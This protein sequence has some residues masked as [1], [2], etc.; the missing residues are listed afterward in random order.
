MKISKIKEKVFEMGV[1]SQQVRD[2]IG[3]LRFRSTWETAYDKYCCYSNLPIIK[4][5]NR[6]WEI[7]SIIDFVPPAPPTFIAPPATPSEPP[8]PVEDDNQY[9]QPRPIPTEDDLKLPLDNI[10]GR[11]LPTEHLL[12][13]FN[14]V[15]T[16]PYLS[17]GIVRHDEPVILVPLDSKAGMWKARRCRLKRLSAYP[18]TLPVAV[19]T[20]PRQSKYGKVS[21]KNKGSR[22]PP[23]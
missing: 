23:E 19:A 3:D 13:L 2:E 8:E 11:L 21:A 7:N 20:S 1:T 6:M 22:S 10:I 14:S 9:E 15:C 18:L 17:K 16:D 4:A 12:T 5:L